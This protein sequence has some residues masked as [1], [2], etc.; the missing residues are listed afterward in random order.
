MAARARSA[1]GG[2]GRCIALS[3]GRGLRAA[4]LLA[5]AVA[6]PQQADAGVASGRFCDF[7]PTLTA[8]QQDR[9]LSFAAI[10]RRELETSG[11]TLAIVARS[12]LDL[13]RF[14]IR[15]THAGLSLAASGNGAWSVRQLYYD[16][17]RGTPRLFDQ[18]LA[19]FVYGGDDPTRGWLSMLL[20]PP[21]AAQPL[22]HSALDAPRAL[23]LVGGAYSANAHAFATRYQNCNQWLAELLALAWGDVPAERAAAQRWLVARGYAPEPVEVDSRLLMFAAGFVPWLHSDDHPEDDLQRLRFRTSLPAA[24]EAF[25]RGLWPGARRI[26]LCHDGARVVVRHGWAPIDDGCVPGTGDRVI[27]LDDDITA[28]SPR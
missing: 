21:E 17:D 23:A 13:S 20:L 26:E 8:T 19:G 7:R 1:A 16:C 25:A 6:A 2:R 24:I 5:A 10:A 15:Y 14:R 4:L 27:A 11:H 28:S 3:R 22:A 18:G 12:G 9:L